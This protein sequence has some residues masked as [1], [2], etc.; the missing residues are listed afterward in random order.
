M[1]APKRRQAAAN[2]PKAT[3][4]ALAEQIQEK[5]AMTEN[6]AAAMV[7]DVAGPSVP[8]TRALAL[9]PP[10]VSAVPELQPRHRSEQRPLKTALRRS[11][12]AWLPAILILLAISAFAPLLLLVGTVTLGIPVLI[13]VILVWLACGKV[14]DILRMNNRSRPGAGPATQLAAKKGNF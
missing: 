6:A 13:F 11:R 5:P 2:R 10:A 7:Q 4:T 3:L 9:L 8:A 1:I 12:F 14:A